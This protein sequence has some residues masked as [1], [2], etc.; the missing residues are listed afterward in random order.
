M[1]GRPSREQLADLG[2]AVYDA[3]L[4]G[5]EAMAQFLR[6]TLVEAV[7]R[8]VAAVALSSGPSAA[9]RTPEQ[10][11]AANEAGHLLH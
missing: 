8:D 10:W 6:S 9:S 3:F 7:G 4:R 2:A 5:P 11:V 1:R